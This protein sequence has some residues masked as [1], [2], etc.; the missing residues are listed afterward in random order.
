LSV[1]PKRRFVIL[2][3]SGTAAYKPGIHW[4]LLCE[5]GNSLKAWEFSQPIAISPQRIT[6]LPPHRTFYLQYEGPISGERGS[7]RQIASGD[8]E[9][10]EDSPNAWT[11]RLS[12]SSLDGVLRLKRLSDNWEANFEPRR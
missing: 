10:L 8:Y 12:S 5:E 6:A 2:E 11:V 4:D 3:H 7:V 9:L 1:N